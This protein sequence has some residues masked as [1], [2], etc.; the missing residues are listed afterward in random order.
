MDNSPESPTPASP[1]SATGSK[2][3]SSRR[4]IWMRLLALI[5]LALA[6]A[7][8]AWWMTH[9]PGAPKRAPSDAPVPSVEVV[10]VSHTASAPT[11]EGYGRVI[12]DRQ[13][14]VS[15]RVSGQLAPFPEGIEAG[16]EVRAN[17]LLAS[18]DQLDYQLALRQA[19]ADLATAEASLASEKGE[20]IRAASEYK[21]F[22]RN[23]PAAQKA[24]VLRE[25]QLK[26]AQA[27]VDSARAS[28]DQARLN[29][30]RTEI[31]APYDGLISE[32]L[33]GE[34]SDLN[35]FTDLLT[36]VATDRFWVRLNLPQADME[37]LSTHARDGQGTPVL[38]SSK[39]W[40]EGQHRRGEVWS[41]LP[42]LEDNGLLTQVMVA[43]E[44]PLA[45]DVSEEARAS[46]PALRLGDVVEATLTPQRTASLIEL[47]VSALRSG[48]QVWVLTED[49]YLEKRAV[50]VRHLGNDTLLIAG[51]LS[52]GERVIVSALSNVEAGMALRARG[53][54]P[55]P[56]TR[57]PDNKAAD[58]KTT[59]GDKSTATVE[60][61]TATGD[62]TATVADKRAT[63]TGS[64]S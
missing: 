30:E 5:I 45:L 49:G 64:D 52:D 50:G 18:L 51:G 61:D 13:T 11:L 39:A 57:T 48:Q 27:A 47:P 60:Q 34:G 16:R 2:P 37:W 42:S 54:A 31:R 7:L 26:S 33:V 59:A 63:T 38:L 4:L 23:L 6:I 19:E 12:V 28:R 40:P 46:T 1:P 53:D 9:R 55:T 25:P 22:G 24:L 10:T 3:P 36:L 29:L 21:T 43:V 15:T 62:K 8:A 14:T 56:T 41:V 44:D 20:Q 58:D 32:R 17:Q 35:A